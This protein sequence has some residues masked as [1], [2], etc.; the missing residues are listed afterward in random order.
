MKIET[1]NEDGEAV[2]WKTPF[3]HDRNHEANRT[4]LVCPEPTKTKQEFKQQQDINHI[5]ATFTRTQQ[6]PDIPVPLQYADLTTLDDYHGMLNKVAETNALFYKL[7]ANIR[8]S[9]QNDPGQWLQ[10]VTDRVTAGD[11]E[12][13]REMGLDLKSYDAQVARLAAEAEDARAAARQAERE[14]AQPPPQ[15]PQTAS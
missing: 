1:I 11:L 6:L 2:R 13:L 10:D 8:A 9:Y 4:A 7:P 3:N 14:A 5:L 12:P 15:P